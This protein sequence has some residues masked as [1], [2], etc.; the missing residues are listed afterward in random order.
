MKNQ[1]IYTNVA[2]NRIWS[3]TGFKVRGLLSKWNDD[4]LFL[5]C[6]NRWWK[7]RKQRKAVY[8]AVMSAQT[9]QFCLCLWCTWDCRYRYFRHRG[10]LEPCVYQKWKW[11]FYF[12]QRSLLRR[13][14]AISHFMEPGDNLAC[15]LLPK[16]KQLAEA[17]PIFLCARGSCLAADYPAHRMLAG[18]G[19][20]ENIAKL[21]RIYAPILLDH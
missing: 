2:R 4:G 13:Q 8:R 1:Q 20:G 19:L 11:N 10:G 12:L 21:K 7:K 14:G 17:D 6:R 3:K 16:Q 5:D 15:P 18:L 9:A